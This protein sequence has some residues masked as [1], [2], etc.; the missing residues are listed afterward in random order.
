MIYA[1]KSNIYELI[2]CISQDNA[3]GHMEENSSHQHN[4]EQENDDYDEG[5]FKNFVENA[6]D[7]EDVE[8]SFEVLSIWFKVSFNRI[9][10]FDYKLTAETV[11]VT[12]IASYFLYKLSFLNL[13]QSLIFD[14]NHMKRSQN[15]NNKAML[16]L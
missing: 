8:Y 6:D 9:F 4:L 13:T 10:S 14:F 12:H 16:H 1:T 15:N 3:A 7:F 5:I 11:Y 2:R